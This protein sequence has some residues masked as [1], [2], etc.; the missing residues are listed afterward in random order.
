MRYYSFAG[1]P[2]CARLPFSRCTLLG[3]RRRSPRRDRCSTRRAKANFRPRFIHR[4]RGWTA[5]EI[6]GERDGFLSTTVAS[7]RLEKCRLP[8][9]RLP[10]GEVRSSSMSLFPLSGVGGTQH[11]A[12]LQKRRG[13]EAFANCIA[14]SAFS[15]TKNA[16]YIFL[17]II[18]A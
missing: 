15:D 16:R 7:R 10:P 17:L 2:N 11:A 5:R 14:P 12:F 8:R 9:G 4:R 18:T 3:P 6:S 1:E 13:F